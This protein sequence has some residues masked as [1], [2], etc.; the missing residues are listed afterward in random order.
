MCNIFAPKL[1]NRAA[2]AERYL[3]KLFT[4]YFAIV[5]NICS[6]TNHSASAVVWIS[7]VVVF[8]CGFARVAVKESWHKVGSSSIDR[9]RLTLVRDGRTTLESS[10]RTAETSL[11]SKARLISKSLK[12]F[13]ALSKR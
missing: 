5:N 3:Q 11:P 9:L 12:Q 13:T 7:H 6:N 10:K 2:Y 4:K 1:K 8:N